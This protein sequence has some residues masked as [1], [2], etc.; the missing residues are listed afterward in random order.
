MAHAWKKAQK[1][2]SG[3]SG[4]AALKLLSGFTPATPKE[5]KSDKGNDDQSNEDGEAVGAQTTWMGAITIRICQAR[6]TRA[7][8][9]VATH[10]IA[11]PF[12]IV[13]LKWLWSCCRCSNSNQIQCTS[14]LYLRVDDIMSSDRS[15]RCQQSTG[16]LTGLAASPNFRHR[17]RRLLLSLFTTLHPSKTNKSVSFD[18]PICYFEFT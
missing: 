1:D 6:R 7:K 15:K 11:P 8:I 5:D 10:A 9:D 16:D 3:T 2:A 18:T 12:Q 17:R 4:V 14:N 13:A